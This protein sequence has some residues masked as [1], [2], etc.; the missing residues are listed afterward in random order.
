MNQN[1]TLEIKEFEIINR[2]NIEINKINVVGGINSSGKSTASKLLYCCIKSILVNK[3]KLLLDRFN[4]CVNSLID[5]IDVSEMSY[6]EV[7]NN[8]YLFRED[9]FNKGDEW[10]RDL[11]IAY[12]INEIDNFIEM[13]NEKDN[14]KIF[15]EVMEMLL[16]N[17][18]LTLRGFFRFFGDSFEISQDEDGNFQYKNIMPD[19]IDDYNKFE[20]SEYVSNLID[21]PK[22]F[23]GIYYFDTVSIFELDD[24]FTN[25]GHIY[26]LNENLK[27]RD[28]V[29]EEL[30]KKLRVIEDKI[31]KIIRGNFETRGYNVPNSIAFVPSTGLDISLR[32]TSSGI[33]QIGAIQLLLRNNKLVPGTFLI[34]DEPEVNLHPEWQFKFAEILVILARDLDVT[35]YLNS[36]SPMFIESIDAFTE[37]YDMKD[38]VNYYLTVPSHRYI[39][40]NFKKIES[41]EL[42]KIYDNLGKPYDLIDQLRLKKHLGE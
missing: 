28:N 18:S 35:I 11:E 5:D 17:E 26:D 25:I 15:H 31:R 6:E 32:N 13:I 39:P 21:E 10:S 42:Y 1:L 14:A 22:I 19:D 4:S 30:S 7:L 33:K 23:N 37:Y 12:N 27:N 36:H 2:A 40:F 29:N 34:I 20:Y 24:F 8:F 9:F 3:R 16:L 41:D 38:S